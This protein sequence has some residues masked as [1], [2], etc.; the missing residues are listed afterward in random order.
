VNVTRTVYRNGQIYF[1]DN[2]KTHYEP[3]QAVCDYGPG[4]D[5]PE[6]AAKKKNLCHPPS[7]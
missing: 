4:T 2:F 7:S 3:W 1:A 6:K 5:D